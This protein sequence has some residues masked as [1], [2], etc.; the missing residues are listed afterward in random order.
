MVV[1]LSVSTAPAFFVF[2]SART[3]VGACSVFEF[4]VDASFSDCFLSTPSGGGV[5]PG[6]V[7]E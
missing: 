5:V 7:G 2:L 4:G 6:K 1:V 3:A